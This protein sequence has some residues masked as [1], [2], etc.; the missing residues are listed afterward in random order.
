MGAALGEVFE[1]TIEI[2]GQLK[3]TGHYVL[4][5]GLNASGGR[6]GVVSF[7][8]FIARECFIG[9][10]PYFPQQ[11]SKLI[12]S[13]DGLQQW[14]RPGKISF[15]GMGGR[16]G[17]ADDSF[18]S[19]IKLNSNEFWD[20]ADGLLEIRHDFTGYEPALWSHS[21]NVGMASTLRLTPTSSATTN[22]M[23]D[24]FRAIQD[25]LLI[26]TNAN[27]SLPWPKLLFTSNDQQY[28][29]D[30]YFKRNSPS[31]D[32]VQWHSTLIQYNRISGSFGTILDT[33]IQKRKSLGPGISLYLGTR[34]NRPLY[35][36]HRF[37]NLVWG[38]EAL[39]RRVDSSK[40]ENPKLKDKIDRL[41]NFVKQADV[42]KL[43]AKD[44]E[45]LLKLLESRGTE[46]PLSDRIYD[47]LKP[48]A[49]G[50]DDKKLQ[51]FCAVC[52]KLRNDLS[53]HGGERKPGDYEEFIQELVVKS[54]ALSK[55]YLLLI[56]SLLGIDESEIRHII[57]QG[58]GSHV[59]T[60]AFSSA[61][62]FPSPDIAEIMALLAST[63]SEDDKGGV[64]NYL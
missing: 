43:A 45:W 51:D 7:E 6:S 14:I 35:L 9:R 16:Q 60:E 25:L 15:S 4:L 19:E 46:R 44:R 32:M 2:A 18:S 48:V 41:K 49:I 58:I 12:I 10:S 55:L 34:R 47:I 56:L 1:E 42:K 13:L 54:N 11:Y 57:H 17:E 52:A 20:I 31:S 36:E 50:L 40:C 37:V 39:D 30:F 29:V 26:L 3:S 38:L 62:L 24:Y 8:S 22:E 23:L 5:R 21:V 59:F 28:G 33:W 53:H 61:G 27:I 64:E 63:R